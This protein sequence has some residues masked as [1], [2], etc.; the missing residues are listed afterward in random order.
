GLDERGMRYVLSY[1]VQ[2]VSGIWSWA[3]D[4]EH[5]EKAFDFA[6]MGAR[7]GVTAAIMVQ[8]GFSGVE[9]GRDGEHNMIEALSTQ[10]DPEEM[11]A[12]LGTRFYVSETALKVFSVGYPI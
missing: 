6:G 4:L 8:D 12:A 1:A 7:N 9:E 11:V 2:Q 5:V 3:R 10:P